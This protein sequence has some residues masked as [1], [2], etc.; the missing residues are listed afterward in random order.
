ME[1]NLAADLFSLLA[2]THKPTQKD[3]EEA[4]DGVPRFEPTAEDLNR[5]AAIEDERRTEGRIACPRR[6]NP[7]D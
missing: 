4:F 6:V 3:Y 2:H 5:M 7:H 1:N